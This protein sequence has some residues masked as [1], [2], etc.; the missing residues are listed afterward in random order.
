[1][2]DVFKEIIEVLERHGVCVEKD[3]ALLE[4][5]PAGRITFTCK[6]L[7]REDFEKRALMNALDIMKILY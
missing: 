6:D 2:K 1:M 5:G 3:S 4:I 7:N